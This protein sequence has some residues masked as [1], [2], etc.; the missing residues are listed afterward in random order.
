M[1]TRSVLREGRRRRALRHAL[2]RMGLEESPQGG[3]LREADEPLDEHYACGGSSGVEAAPCAVVS[4]APM[5]VRG[6]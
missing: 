2:R 3:L 1:G 6:G 5:E 4:G